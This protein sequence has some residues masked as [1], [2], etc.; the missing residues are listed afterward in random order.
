[1]LKKTLGPTQAIVIIVAVVAIVIG[2]GYYL[3]SGGSGSANPLPPAQSR[4]EMMQNLRARGIHA[5]G[6]HATEQRGH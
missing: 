5:G 6:S 3:T 1:M 2:V 4:A